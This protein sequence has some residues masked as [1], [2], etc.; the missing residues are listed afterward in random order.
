MR[1]FEGD[2][3]KKKSKKSTTLLLCLSVGLPPSALGLENSFR[4]LETRNL[5]SQSGTCLTASLPPPPRPRS[6]ARPII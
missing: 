6:L 5:L 2:R 3:A 4:T 1:A